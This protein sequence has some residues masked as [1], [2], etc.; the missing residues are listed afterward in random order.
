MSYAG[1]HEEGLSLCL[2]SL[3]GSP[4]REMYS[5]PQGGDVTRSWLM[6]LAFPAVLAA[7]ERSFMRTDRYVL[8]IEQYLSA[9]LTFADIDGD[10]DM[11]AVVANGRH[12]PQPNEVFVNNGTGR[13]TVSYELGPHATTY[14]VPSGDLDGDGDFDLVVANDSAEN[15]VYLNDGSGHFEPAWP[16]GAELEPTRSAQLYDL[17]GDG[18]LDLLITNRGTSN[19]F[20]LNDGSG[21]FGPKREFGEPQGSTIA[22]A[23]G[24]V[25]G[26]GNPDLV[27]ANRDGQANHILLNDGR[28]GFPQKRSYGTGSDETRSAALADLNG[29]NIL[30]IVNV[31]IGEPN[32]IYLGDGSG[33]F[34]RGTSVGGSEQSYAL[35]LVDVD[36][37]G[38]ID[39]VVANVRGRNELYLNDGTGTEWIRTPIGEESYVTYGVAAADLN[40]DGFVDLG[41]AN[42]SGPNLIFL[43][44]EAGRN[45]D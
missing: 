39:V 31:N 23:V 5:R 14:A 9:G 12:W 43:N 3:I 44:V 41:F 34:D 15:W 11:D 8:G 29:D 22:V 2:E 26:D 13:F 16:V 37:D 6:V 4:K 30:D 10:G 1:A 18:D 24:D 27:L 28:L 42:S 38:D 7:Q 45:R 19:G 17:D 36:R 21:R 32:R 40:G 33:G 35:E 20:F 25:D